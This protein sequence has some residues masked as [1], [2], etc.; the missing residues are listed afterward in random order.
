MNGAWLGSKYL[1]VSGKMFQAV[2]PEGSSFQSKAAP[3]QGCTGTPRWVWYQALRALGSRALRKTPPM[4][5]T[6]AMLLARGGGGGNGA[7][8]DVLDR[9]PAG[10]GAPPDGEVVAVVVQVAVRPRHRPNVGPFLGRQVARDPDRSGGE[11]EGRL[12]GPELG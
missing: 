4:P 1:V 12:E 5:V 11:A 8:P 9:L 10:G 2:V 6:R 3:P 7:V